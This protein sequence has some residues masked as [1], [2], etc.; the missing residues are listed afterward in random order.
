M[1]LIS[2]IIPV[3]NCEQ[4]LPRCLDSIINQTHKNLEI[5]CINDGSTDN[6]LKILKEYSKKDSRIILISQENNKQGAA[7]N[8]GLDIAKGEFIT[9]VDADDWLD[10]NY[11]ELLYNAAQRYDV[12]IAAAS[13]TRDYKN[14]VKNH[15]KLKEENV[16]KDVNS[17]VK[18]L[19]YNFITHSKL[20]RFEPI[21]N[22]RFEEN[23]LYE[24]G[25]YTIKAFDIEKSLVTVPDAR[26]HYFSN[27]TST[28]KQKKDVKK[29]ND[30]ISTS[31]QLIRYA[32]ENNI[33][34][35]SKNTLVYKDDHFWW[36][37]KHYY[38]KKEVYLCGIKIST[39]N[40]PFN[41]IKN[42][43]IFNTA[44]FGDVLLCN[45]LVQNIKNVFPESRIIFVCDK[46]WKDVVKY[47]EGVDEVITY[48]KKGKNK[49]IY[50]L[51]KFIK[52]FKYKNI[53]A[54]FITYKNERNYTIAKLLKS[55]FIFMN[56][57]T[58]ENYSVQ[59][60]HSMLLEPLTHKKIIN[61][62]IKYNLPDDIINPL[63]KMDINNKYIALCCTTKN[64]IKDMP[65]NI[66]AEIINKINNESPYKVVLVGNDEKA[67]Q[68]ANDLNDLN[69]DFINLV[70]K[71]SLLELGK[72]LKDSEGLISVDTGT[73]HFG[74]SLGVKTL[75]LFFEK[76]TT[77]LWAP[78][79]KIYNHT[80]VLSYDEIINNLSNNI[81][82]FIK[83]LKENSDEII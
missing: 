45:S 28:I 58:K 70:K 7:R 41:N 6:S 57:L 37:V 29:E 27:P 20:Y 16:Y 75:C 80:Y 51:I 19:E 12:N 1:S 82:N 32:K 72:V 53:Y 74:Y 39:K 76:G 83:T 68:L 46:N 11:C 65:I 81:E 59:N 47:Q 67:K 31:L 14:K 77:H 66:A 71:T 42:F 9:F 50:G 52:D 48:D 8:K 43:V 21:K 79:K 40:I 38:D 5:I 33:K 23:V 49:G 55:K 63:S 3:Y 24:D 61:C 44:Y 17:I 22:L 26:Y 13:T 35:N 15:L 60:K 69:C 30:K 2:V 18:A 34:I 64:S 54:S 25:A 78:E 73:M 10:L 56:S 62:P 36:A 4:Y